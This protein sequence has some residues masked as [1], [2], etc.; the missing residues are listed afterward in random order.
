MATIDQLLLL[1]RF[2]RNCLQT[3]PLLLLLQLLISPVADLK[4]RHLV[5]AAALLRSL[6]ATAD[7]TL[8]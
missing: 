2:Q 1:L 5:V 8:H 6:A 3:P 7:A 4:G